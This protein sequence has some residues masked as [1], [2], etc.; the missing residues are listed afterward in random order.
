MIHYSLATPSNGQ[1]TRVHVDLT[2]HAFE[3]EAS[4]DY[5]TREEFMR[6]LVNVQA[7][8]L[9]ATYSDMP[10]LAELRDVSMD[11]AA[12]DGLGDVASNVEQ[13]QCPPN[14]AG[15]SCERCADGFYRDAVT[16]RCVP[17]QCNGHSESCDPLTGSCEVC[18]KVHAYFYRNEEFLC[19]TH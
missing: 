12:V 5:P 13:C 4:G 18:N 7:I 15:T 16:N 19:K 17:C 2:E 8:Q 1:L 6:M 3:H 11:T 14:Y 10:T 9:R